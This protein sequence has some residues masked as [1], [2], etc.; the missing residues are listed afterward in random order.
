MMLSIVKRKLH[1]FFTYEVH[2]WMTGRDK[3]LRH[4]LFRQARKRRYGSFP[5]TTLL[6]KSSGIEEWAFQLKLDGFNGW[7]KHLKGP[8]DIVQIEAGHLA[9]IKEPAVRSVVQHLNS[10]LCD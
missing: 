7:K 2:R 4:A 3:D 9:M 1:N 8:R 5:G 10:V 6:F